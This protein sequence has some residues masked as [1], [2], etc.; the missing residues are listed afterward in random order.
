MD[1]L[2]TRSLSFHDTERLSE[3]FSAI[4]WSKPAAV[5]H[6]YLEE[7]G[8]GARWTRVAEWNGEP[9]GYV[10]IA[11]EPAD[12]EFARRGIPEIMDLNVLPRFRNRGIGSALIG[13]AELEVSKRSS[14]VGIRVG[15]HSGYGAAQRLYVQRGYV[16]DG[17]G[18]V[19]SGLAPAEGSEI[20]LDD[21]ATLRMIK[22]FP[23]LPPPS[24]RSAAF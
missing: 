18:V 20:R 17:A 19:V 5:F 10:T 22:R 12:P 16:P 2:R 23:A 11:W 3:A 1:E 15:L 4:G 21:E 7:E 6:R 13:E 24:P 8:R 14:A 9:A